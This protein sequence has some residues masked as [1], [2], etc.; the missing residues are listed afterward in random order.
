ML[1]EVNSEKLF[2]IGHTDKLKAISWLS[3]TLFLTP[4]IS[5]SPYDQGL[6]M[7]YSRPPNNY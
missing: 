3:V 5:T 2:T 6:E 1:H 4:S 7:S